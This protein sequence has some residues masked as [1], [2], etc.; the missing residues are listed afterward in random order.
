MMSSL[1]INMSQ[2]KFVQSFQNC[3]KTNCHNRC[4]CH[5]KTSVKQYCSTTTMEQIS[6]SHNCFAT[7]KMWIN[8]DNSADKTTL[9]AGRNAPQHYFPAG[10]CRQWCSCISSYVQSAIDSSDLIAQPEL[11]SWWR[12]SAFVATLFLKHLS[13]YYWLSCT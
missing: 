2:N 10:L 12:I 7:W 6:Y 4:L 5:L 9:L 8:D 11:K 3:H 13:C 1:T